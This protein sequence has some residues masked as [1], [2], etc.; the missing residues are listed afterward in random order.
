MTACILSIA[1]VFGG[2]AVPCALC[3]SS[4]EANAE[5]RSATAD[6]L[7]WADRPSRLP[8]AGNLGNA[9]IIA[10][11]VR[12]LELPRATSVLAEGDLRRY[13][14]VATAMQRMPP[15]DV[16]L[17]VA[18]VLGAADLCE[19][20]LGAEGLRLAILTRIAFV[21][22]EAPRPRLLPDGMRAGGV[23]I[24]PIAPEHA[25][26]ASA[27]ASP[28]SWRDGQPQ[29]IA[30]QGGGGGNL[31]FFAALDEWRTAVEFLPKRDLE[32]FARGRDY[33]EILHDLLIEL[34]PELSPDD[35]DPANEE[36]PN[37]DRK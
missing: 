30:T 1:V 27:E 19:G 8:D 32:E 21:F 34:D 3:A 7:G 22:D 35:E 6:P 2:F 5:V 36:L 33:S 26:A 10:K 17:A 16:D 13:Q 29:M 11:I 18:C 24:V 15:Q 23:P 20:E 12:L 14:L 28:L 31:N 4:D 9:I 37:E 25:D